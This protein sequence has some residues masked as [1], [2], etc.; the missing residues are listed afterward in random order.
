MIIVNYW[1]E[2]DYD[3]TTDGYSLHLEGIVNDVFDIVYDAEL[4]QQAIDNDPDFEP[5]PETLYEI[6]L[7]R[8]TIA[9]DPINE[10]AFAI[11][12]VIEKKYDSDCGWVTPLVRM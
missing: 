12:R 4:I 6:Q 2:K 1:H 9:S 5:K 11:D 7:I 8:A 3:P 10:P